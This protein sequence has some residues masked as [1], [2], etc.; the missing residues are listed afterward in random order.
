M[1]S[2]GGLMANDERIQS[3]ILG[4][5]RPNK[6]VSDDRTAHRG[7][8]REQHD[9][10]SMEGGSKHDRT[11]HPGSRDVTEGVTGGLRTQTRG[12]RQFRPGTGATGGGISERPGK[13]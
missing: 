5:I 6:D 11:E 7:G 9:D 2:P 13:R 10:E 3:G 8:T 12:P 4:D 1:N